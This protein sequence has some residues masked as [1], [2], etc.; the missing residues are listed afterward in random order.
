MTR[1]DGDVAELVGITSGA[2]ASAA[3]QIAKRS[4]HAGKLIVT[5][6]PDTSERCCS[7][8]LFAEPSA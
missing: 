7:T 1:V 4:E 2:A 3:V 6:L 5:L 8:A